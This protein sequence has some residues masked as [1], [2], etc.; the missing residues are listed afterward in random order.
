MSAVDAL[1]K[2]LSEYQLAFVV[3]LGIVGFLAFIG[4]P[5]SK[6]SKSNKTKKAPS[7]PKRTPS[8]KEAASTRMAA[9]KAGSVET[10]AGRRSA[11]IARK[12]VK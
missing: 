2:F 1:H 9:K 11:R 7:T 6:S 3:A 4:L 12:Q 10:P 8:R 5:K